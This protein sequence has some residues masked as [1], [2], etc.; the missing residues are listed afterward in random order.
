MLS[1]QKYKKELTATIM[2]FY[3]Y[4]TV[5]YEMLILLMILHFFY[6]EI[7]IKNTV[8]ISKFT[9]TLPENIKKTPVL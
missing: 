4:R 7:V 2:S 8:K 5:I 3:I 9:A 6:S 1:A